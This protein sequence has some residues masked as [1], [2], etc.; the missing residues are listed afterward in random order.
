MIVLMILHMQTWRIYTC[1]TLRD[2][3]LNLAHFQSNQGDLVSML[4]T[5]RCPSTAGLYT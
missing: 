1:Q 2:V 3:L 5:A 4:N